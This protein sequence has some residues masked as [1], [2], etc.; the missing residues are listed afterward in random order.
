MLSSPMPQFHEFGG[1]MW[2]YR[3]EVIWPPYQNTPTDRWP[4]SREV[5]G[6]W[7]RQSLYH[8]SRVT[9]FGMGISITEEDGFNPSR[10]SFR[11]PIPLTRS[12]KAAVLL[13]P[14]VTSRGPKTR[15]PPGTSIEI[16]LSTGPNRPSGT[17]RVQG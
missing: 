15:P 17:C 12:L 11:Y 4:V 7:A 13:S 14:S 9:G 2:L 16:G 8:C 1:M 6:L 10:W 3:P 5:Y